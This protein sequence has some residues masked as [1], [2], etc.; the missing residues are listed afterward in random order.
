MAQQQQPAQPTT[1]IWCLHAAAARDAA[2]DGTPTIDD[3]T[4]ATDGATTAAT[5]GAT[6]GLYP[7]V[8]WRTTT[9]L[10]T[11]MGNVKCGDR[12]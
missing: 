6:T 12:D 5:D 10:W 2:T 8:Q 11:T 3:A 9:K 1:T 4:T 7:T